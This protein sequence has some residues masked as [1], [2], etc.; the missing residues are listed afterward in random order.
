MDLLLLA[1][2]APVLCALFWNSLSSFSR[3][4]LLLSPL[5]FYVVQLKDIRL[6]FLVAIIILIVSFNWVFTMEDDR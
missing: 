6:V 1:C 2:L 5:Y 4:S 3:V